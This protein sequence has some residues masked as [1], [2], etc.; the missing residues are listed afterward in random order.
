MSFCGNFGHP[1]ST[2]NRIGTLLLAR[3]SRGKKK[4]QI[5]KYKDQSGIEPQSAF[6][7]SPI[8]VITLHQPE[9]VSV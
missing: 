1:L 4:K 3:V 6:L 2:A 5:N 8:M 7:G 9:I